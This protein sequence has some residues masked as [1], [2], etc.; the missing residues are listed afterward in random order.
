MKNLNSILALNILICTLCNAAEFSPAS[1]WYTKYAE[2]PK[3]C[4]TPEQMNGRRIPPLSTPPDMETQLLQVTGIFRHGA[5]TPYTDYQCWTGWDEQKWDCELKTLTAPPAQPEILKLAK[6]G[7]ENVELDGEG[8][9]FLFEKSYDALHDPPQLRNFLNGTCQKGQL[10][11]K[12]YSQELH[13]GKMLRQT[14]VR[15][16]ESGSQTAPD[17]NEIRDDMVLFDLDDGSEKRP[18]EYPNLYYRADD[19]QRTI[20]SGQV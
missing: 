7:V 17:K 6:D 19:D 16:S 13:N 11:L 5:R 4:S 3:Y 14:Y 2:Y 12:G 15:E 9:M 8:V 10:I 1:D 20:M 18:Y